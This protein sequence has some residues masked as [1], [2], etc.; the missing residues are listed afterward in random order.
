MNFHPA[1]A[2]AVMTGR[3]NVTRRLVSDNPRSP[4]HPERIAALVGKDV[5]ICPGR[6]KHSIGRARIQ[7]VTI[8]RFE[9]GRITYAEAN[10]EGCVS[11]S[12]FMGLWARIHG[13]FD[14]V[15]VWRIELRPLPRA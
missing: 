8:E 9:P 15:V 14:A 3:K 7:R 6:G 11:E 10:A 4:Y 2:A 13:S 12:E 1:L 5:A